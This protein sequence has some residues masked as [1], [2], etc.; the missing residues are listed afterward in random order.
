MMRRLFEHFEE[1]V[2]GSLLVVMCLIGAV[3]VVCRYVLTSPLA[4][5]EELATMLFAW[6]VFLGASL[7]LKKNEHFAIDVVVN[8]LPARMRQHSS[9]VRHAAVVIFCLLLIGYGINLAVLSWYVLTPML[10]ISRGWFYLSVPFGGLLMLVRTIEMICRG[11]T[12]TRSPAPFPEPGEV[13]E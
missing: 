13:V 8:L 9:A 3:K 1:I 2:G 7:A 12:E 4:W 6:L 10:E 5:T 11:S